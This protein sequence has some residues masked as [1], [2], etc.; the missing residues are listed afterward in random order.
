MASARNIRRCALQAMYQ[1]DA[2]AES[3]EAV[4]SSLEEAPGGPEACE[5][6][7]AL[8]EAAWA[9]RCEADAAVAALAP[10]WPTHRQPAIDRNILRL[11]YYEMTDG[12]VPPKV[13]INEAIELAREFSTA[14][15][16]MFVNGVLDKIYKAGTK[17]RRHEGTT[18]PDEAQG[19]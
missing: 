7:L 2:G 16:P 19:A 12:G 17:A 6:G 5:R 3:V 18:C 8:A 13:V 11:A 10:E 1:L 15:S 9:T 14:K 4:R